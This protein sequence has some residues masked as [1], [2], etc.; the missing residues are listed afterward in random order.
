LRKPIL[1]Y[2]SGSAS[3]N[4]SFNVPTGL[5]PNLVPVPCAVWRCFY[6]YVLGSWHRTMKPLNGRQGLSSCL[7]YKD[8]NK[9][10]TATPI[11]SDGKALYRGVETPVSPE[12][13]IFYEPSAERRRVTNALTKNSFRS[14]HVFSNVKHSR[15]GCESFVTSFHKNI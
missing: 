14:T 7:T 1:E 5:S 4:S 10:F 6:I 9:I 2:N 11:L 12:K 3:T 8:T 15:I 13:N